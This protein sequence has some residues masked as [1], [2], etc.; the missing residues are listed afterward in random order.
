MHDSFSTVSR[1]IPG[2]EPGQRIPG[3]EVD[4][5]DLVFIVEHR[6]GRVLA[7]GIS[8]GTGKLG[9]AR[10]DRQRHAEVMNHAIEEVARDHE[11]R[12]ADILRLI[13]MARC[14]FVVGT[15]GMGAHLQHLAE[16][17][18]LQDGLHRIDRR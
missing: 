1:D 8:E 2:L 6:A 11:H 4:D 9:D 3:E 5:D 10:I 12:P 7:R 13:D 16:P 18:T 17:A 14:S 15:A